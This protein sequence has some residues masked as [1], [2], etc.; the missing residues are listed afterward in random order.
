MICPKKNR[1]DKNVTIR[2]ALCDKKA[3]EVLKTILSIFT[4]KASLGRLCG[5]LNENTRSTCFSEKSGSERLT[6]QEF[7][8]FMDQL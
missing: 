3:K 1:L 4:P 6:V 2:F 7:F 5:L 8:W